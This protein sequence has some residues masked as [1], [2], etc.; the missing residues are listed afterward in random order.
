MAPMGARRMCALT[1]PRF[2]LS[3]RGGEGA[4]WG[5]GCD[6]ES[7]S[8]GGSRGSGG[9]RRAPGRGR[10]QHEPY[11]DLAVTAITS[12]VTYAEIGG[13]LRRRDRTQD[14]KDE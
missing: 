1:V 7:E 6:G 10:G 14:S 2:S 9:V 13:W 8:V 4:P 3:P 11:V 12:L 5:D